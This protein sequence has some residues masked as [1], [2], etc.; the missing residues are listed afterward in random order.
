MIELFA[1]S[2]NMASHFEKLGFDTFTV[3]IEQ[4]RNGS[5]DLVQDI[6]KIT[7][8]DLPQEPYVIWASPPCTYY[9]YARG[10]NAV[11]G[12]GGIPLTEEAH[13]ANELVKHT[14]AIIHQLQPQYWFLENPR[15]HLAKQKFMHK[16][17]KHQIR[18]CNYGELFEKPTDLWGRFPIRFV[19]KNRCRHKKHEVTVTPY[20]YKDET[21]GNYRNF[22]YVTPGRRSVLPDKLCEAISESVVESKGA[23]SYESL[24]EWL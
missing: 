5:I 19:P 13:Q 6:S 15:G 2:A 9:S 21:K 14:L 12:P 4:N 1:G 22:K 17:M 10:K 23:Y 24:E 20:N 3:D 7:P 8:D 16:Y 18:Y 11:F